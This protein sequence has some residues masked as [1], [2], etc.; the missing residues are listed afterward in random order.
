MADF[1]LKIVAKAF[2]GNYEPKLEQMVFLNL[3]WQR[4]RSQACC[5]ATVAPGDRRFQAWH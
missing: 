5:D 1:Y 4:C 2:I 3:P